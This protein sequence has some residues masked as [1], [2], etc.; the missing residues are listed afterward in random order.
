VKKNKKIFSLVLNLQP[1][2]QAAVLMMTTSPHEKK[3]KKMA[4]EIQTFA[5]ATSINTLSAGVK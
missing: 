1:L 4:P 3:F 5:F 2:V